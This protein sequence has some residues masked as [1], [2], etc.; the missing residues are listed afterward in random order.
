M[1]NF[2]EMQAAAI[3]QGNE[4][5]KDGVKHRYDTATFITPDGD[6]FKLQID[7]LKLPLKAQDTCVFGVRSV[8]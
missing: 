7:G 3:K 5:E 2:L 1:S 4:Y 6:S 8:M